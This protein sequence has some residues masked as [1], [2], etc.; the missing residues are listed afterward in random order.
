MVKIVQFHF[1]LFYIMY[2]IVR[3][4]RGNCLVM[5]LR[6]LSKNEVLTDEWAII[7]L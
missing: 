5:Q 2:F 6:E 7:L 4:K 3:K 1:Q